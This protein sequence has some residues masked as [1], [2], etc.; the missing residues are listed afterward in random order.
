LIFISYRISDANQFVARL[1]DSLSVEFGR[2]AVF[3]DKT[4]IDGGQD[5]PQE[6][7]QNAKS[8]PIMLVVISKTWESASFTQGKYKGYPRLHDPDDWVRRE[9]G[10]AFNTSKTVIPILVDGT[11]MPGKAGVP[12]V[13][14]TIYSLGLKPCIAVVAGS[15]LDISSSRS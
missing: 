5:W 1:D 7:E 14:W 8:R 9:I 3:R 13:P 15:V 4:R 11:P 10:I 12:P 2:D 6:I